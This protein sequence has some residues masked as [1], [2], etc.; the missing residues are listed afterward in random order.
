MQKAHELVSRVPRNH[1]GRCCYDSLS[2]VENAVLVVLCASH[3]YFESAEMAV[4]N[5]VL[6]IVVRRE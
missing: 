2:A 3:R 6:V 4:V 5:A 1:Q